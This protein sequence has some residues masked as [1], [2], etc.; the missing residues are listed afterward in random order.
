MYSL[1]WTG[2]VEGRPDSGPPV[3]A[4][5]TSAPG[6]D[7]DH[8]PA[9]SVFI[10]GRSHGPAAEVFARSSSLGPADSDVRTGGTEKAGVHCRLVEGEAKVQGAVWR[11]Q[12]GADDRRRWLGK[13][14]HPWT[15]SSRAAAAAMTCSGRC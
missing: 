4:M 12:V 7:A 15:A 3:A 14:S 2:S 9:A 11:G 13:M 10:G 8:A 1:I 5:V 6:Q